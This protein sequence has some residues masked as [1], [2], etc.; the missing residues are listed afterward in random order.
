[1]TDLAVAGFAGKVQSII[2]ELSVAMSFVFLLYISLYCLRF[3]G[4]LFFKKIV[5]MPPTFAFFSM[6]II[7]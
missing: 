6:N 7:F 5:N 4:L 2:L 1:M 3:L